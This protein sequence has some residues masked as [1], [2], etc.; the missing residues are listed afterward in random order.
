MNPIRVLI[1]DD[2]AVIR[3]IYTKILSSDPEIQVVG[4][5][6]DPYVAREKIVS[7]SP[8]V[9]T[10][11]IEMPR[12][13]GLTFLEA[14]MKHHPIRT[15][16]ISSLSTQNSQ[17]ALRALEIGAI[18]VMAKPAIDVTQSLEALR[19]ELISA[20]KGV[21]KARLPAAKTPAVGGPVRA[22]VAAN[23]NRALN[24]TTHQ[25][26]AIASSTGGTEALK[27]VLPHLPSDLPGT[28]IVQHMPPVFTKAFAD[29]LNK[30]CPFEV[31]EAQDG[32][33]VMPGLALLAPGNFHME[34][35]RSGAD[36]RIRLHQEPPMHGVRPAADFL[37][38][39]VA[40]YAGKNAI[41]L[42]LTGMGRDGAKGLAEMK[43]AG[44]Y[45]IAQDESSCVVFGMPKE[46]I[47]A[48]AIDRILPLDQIAGELM[49]QFEQRSVIDSGVKNLSRV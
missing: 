32:D 30:L 11:D 10:L 24:K 7:L 13:D 46:A 26:L 42:V 4:T 19:N 3:T 33:R 49:D 36:Y 34:L 45:N 37:M 29:A 23:T 31:R 17:T 9:L 15:L 25:I 27:A 6:P 22:P 12:M 38:K 39:T 5:A 28:V 8:D 20:V 41:G 18:E 47:A 48:G 43:Q 16:V 21:A 14:L 35:T 1:V 44:S 2:S 40:K